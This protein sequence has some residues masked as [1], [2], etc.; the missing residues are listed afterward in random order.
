M[1]RTSHG[2]ELEAATHIVSPVRNKREVTASFYL[3]QDP[4]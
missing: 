1:V 2:Q 3:L 4:S